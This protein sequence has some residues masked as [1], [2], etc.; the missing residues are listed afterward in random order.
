MEV[1][2][3]NAVLARLFTELFTDAITEE[4]YDAELAGLKYSVQYGGDSITIGS[5][6]YNDKLPVLTSKMVKLMKDFKVDPAR[7]TVIADQVRFDLLPLM[8]I[9]QSDDYTH[10]HS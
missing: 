7:Y 3:R 4:V 8:V 5:V 10:I 2:P 6:G 1:T 9:T